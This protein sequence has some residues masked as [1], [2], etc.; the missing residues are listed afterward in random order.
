VRNGPSRSR[1]DFGRVNFER[2]NAFSASSSGAALQQIIWRFLSL[3]TWRRIWGPALTLLGL[4][5]QAVR[6][7]WL[8]LDVLGRLDVLWRI[9]ESTG[10]S[11]ALVVSVISSW[12]FGFGLIV[13]GLA[14]TIFV[15][16]PKAGVQRHPALP[17][18]A[19]SVFAICA[20][21]LAGFAIYGEYEL[22]LRKAYAEGASGIP[23]NSSPANPKSESNQR[24]IYSNAPRNLKPDQ[25]RVLIAEGGR[26]HEELSNIPIT[27]LATDMEAFS[28]ASELNTTFARAAIQTGNVSPQPLGEPGR[29]GIMIEVPDKNAPSSRALKLQQLLLIAD[30]QAPFVTSLPQFGSTPVILFVGPRPLQ[31][32]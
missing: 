3:F 13:V 24:P 26:L 22:Q 4:L 17:Y 11:T 5:L 23:R 16:E 9:V 27:F 29:E 2:P 25:Q 12:Q 20:T 10:G 14:Y 32:Y 30:I 15:G 19:A 8:S 21:S 7:G 6:L 28:Y 1:F 31:R 18:I